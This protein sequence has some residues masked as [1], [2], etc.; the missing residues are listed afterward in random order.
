MRSPFY[1]SRINFF[2]QIVYLLFQASPCKSKVKLFS[3]YSSLSAIPRYKNL[4]LLLTLSRES[5]NPQISSSFPEPPN[6]CLKNNLRVVGIITS[7]T[8]S[9]T[10][11]AQSYSSNPE[12]C[13]IRHVWYVVHLYRLPIVP[14]YHVRSWNKSIRH[15]YPKV[16]RLF[17]LL[18]R[19]KEVIVLFDSV[20]PFENFHHH[21]TLFPLVC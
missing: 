9:H 11:L 5:G 7:S 3:L 16:L 20:A 18:N 1:R 10:I 14:S 13:S 15:P 2:S 6:T 12:A 21:Q 4:C 8:F 17:Y 19:R